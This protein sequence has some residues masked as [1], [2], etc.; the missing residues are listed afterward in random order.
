MR[1]IK[2]TVGYDNIITLKLHRNAIKCDT[3]KISHKTLAK[4]KLLNSD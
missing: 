2:R 4:T 1:T 3:Q